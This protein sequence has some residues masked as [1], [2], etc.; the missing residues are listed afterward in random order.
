[1]WW[2]EPVGRRAL[3]GL[4]LGCAGLAGCNLRPL[5]GGSRGAETDRELAAIEVSA[6]K[7]RV[8]QK[9]KNFLLDDLNPRG[10]SELGR[11]ELTVR[12]QASRTALIVQLDGDITRYDLILAAFYELRD[13]ADKKVLYRSAARRVASFNLR[14]APYATLISQ[15]NAED[16]AARE[17]S[18]Y[19]RSQLALFFASKQQA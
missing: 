18:T 6:T 5:H 13:K 8:G 2:S 19:I 3:L 16:R 10:A 17:L 7:S 14:R 15:D 9:L 12:T 11:Y 1:M 4:A